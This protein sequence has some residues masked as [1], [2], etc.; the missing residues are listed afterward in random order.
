MNRFADNGDFRG[1]VKLWNGGT[2]GLADR[3]SQ[4]ARITKILQGAEW[5]EIAAAPGKPP[6]KPF[7]DPAPP[8][9]AQ[10]E[11]A[12]ASIRTA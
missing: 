5:G 2:N 6:P 7:P 12:P 8:D 4:L 11:S 10:A 1:C 9:P 3:Q